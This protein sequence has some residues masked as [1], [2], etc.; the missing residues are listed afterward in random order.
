MNIAIFL[1]NRPHFGTTLIHLPLIHSLQLAYPDAN[2]FLFSKNDSSYLLSKI[3]CIKKVFVTKNR[4]TEIANYRTI[5][6]DITISLRKNS[7][8]LSVMLLL[9]K[10]KKY[11]YNNTITR[12]FFTKSILYQK[13]IYRASNFLN[14]LP[15]EVT[16][17]YFHSEK[18][19]YI[20][21]IPAGEYKI[22]HW[23]I[24]NY[25]QLADTFVKLYPLL[26]INFVLGEAEREYLNVIKNHSTTYSIYF[27]KSLNELF[28]I[29][30]SS[31]LVVANDCGPAHIAQISD[32]A[33]IILYSDENFT[34]KKTINEWF[35]KKENARYVISDKGK[36]INTI[37]VN[38]VI[39]TA[40]SLLI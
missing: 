15:H 3:V 24:Q 28:D 36:S 33:N 10:G 8:F 18:K 25:L 13:N 37:N 2:I 34:A 31:K 30:I 21:L 14:L 32:T 38:A 27:N 7:L 1:Q 22:K 20:T 35:R 5:N 19:N 29:I 11:A 12:L 40:Q 16:A 23:N 6:F 39:K 26:D 17:H 9:S 4:F